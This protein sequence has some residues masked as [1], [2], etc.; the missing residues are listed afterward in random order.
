MPMETSTG[1]PNNSGRPDGFACLTFFPQK[2]V[3][4]DPHGAEGKHCIITKNVKLLP[5]GGRQI[6]IADFLKR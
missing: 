5:S 2:E 3:E 6:T 1:K 4:N